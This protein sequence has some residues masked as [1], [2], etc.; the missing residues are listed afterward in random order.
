MSV[1]TM[2]NKVHKHTINMRAEVNT[3]LELQY[4]VVN[5]MRTQTNM[6]I[7]SQNTDQIQ[8]DNLAALNY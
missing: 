2:L 7:G 5:K 6:V 3:S 8:V 1:L 4:V